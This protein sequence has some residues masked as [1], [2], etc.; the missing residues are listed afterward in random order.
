MLV[1][2]EPRLHW[3]SAIRHSTMAH[4]LP[5]TQDTQ[6][7]SANLGV[8]AGDDNR[9]VALAP[10]DRAFITH[11]DPDAASFERLLALGFVPG[12]AVE[13]IRRAPLGDP[14][15]YQV[16]GT[17]ICLRESEAS[18]IRIRIPGEE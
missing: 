3:P 15:E 16:R 17:R 13:V 5:T 2:K 7:S 10:G 14:V 9:L 18:L 6:S 4:P 11:V 12:S 1:N 8:G